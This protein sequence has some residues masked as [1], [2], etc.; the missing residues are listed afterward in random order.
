[1]EMDFRLPILSEPALAVVKLVYFFR[2]AKAF[3]F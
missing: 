1:M 2:S 3:S